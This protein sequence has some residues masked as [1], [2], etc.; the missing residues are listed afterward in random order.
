MNAGIRHCY[1]GFMAYCLIGTVAYSHAAGLAE[2]AGK[3]A[4]QGPREEMRAHE[5]LRRE[6]VTD[7]QRETLKKA[8]EPPRSPGY[9]DSPQ[10]PKPFLAP[11]HP[12]PRSGKIDLK[13]SKDTGTT[14]PGAAREQMRAAPKPTGEQAHDPRPQEQPSA[15]RLNARKHGEKHEPHHHSQQHSRP[16]GGCDN[17]GSPAEVEKCRKAREDFQR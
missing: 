14:R 17:A 12:N 6:G 2:H 5:R 13:G 16:S 8:F 4:R 1:A 10:K 15:D 9:G 3:D 11:I 7:Q